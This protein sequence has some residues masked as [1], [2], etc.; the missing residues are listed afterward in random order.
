MATLREYFDADFSRV[1]NV[2]STLSLTR[3][4]EGR[5][6]QPHTKFLGGCTTT[7]TAAPSTFRISFHRVPT[8][9]DYAFAARQMLLAFG[10]IPSK[11]HQVDTTLFRVPRFE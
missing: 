5:R 2:A 10:C 11:K 1:M 3:A 4:D 6:L 9:P 7:L 8:P